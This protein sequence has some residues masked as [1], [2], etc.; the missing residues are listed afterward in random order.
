MNKKKQQTYTVMV[1]ITLDTTVHIKAESM[2]EA[3]A[4]AKLLEVTEVVQFDGDHNDSSIEVTG[5]FK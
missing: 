4:E 2:E 5:V 1:S 3:I